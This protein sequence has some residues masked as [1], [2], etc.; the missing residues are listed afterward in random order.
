MIDEHLFVEALALAAFEIVYQNPQPSNAEKII[1]LMEK[2]QHSEGPA[3]VQ[4][5]LGKARLIVQNGADPSDLLYFIKQNHP[6]FFNLPY[7]EPQILE[8]DTTPAKKDKR[9]S[10]RNYG[11]MSVNKSQNLDVLSN[12]KAN[13]ADGE[14]RFDSYF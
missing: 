12:R 1:L 2:L 5:E 14:K 9:V 13:P 10:Q 3:K 6:H 4:R 8:Q 7:E 11:Q